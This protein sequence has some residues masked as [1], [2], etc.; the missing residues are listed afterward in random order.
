MTDEQE[1]NPAFARSLSNAG[2]GVVRIEH[3]HRWAGQLADRHLWMATID[4]EVD[5]YARKDALI[6][7]AEKEGREW[8]VVR[9]HQGGGESVVLRSS[10]NVK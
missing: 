7:Q 6:R 9:H 2:L 8:Y 3:V 4:G 5:D 1:M 10:P